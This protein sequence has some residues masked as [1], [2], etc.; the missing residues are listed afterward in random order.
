LIATI[1]AAVFVALGLYVL[2]WWGRTKST[3]VGAL[4]WPTA[5]GVITQSHIHHP[6]GPDD[7]ALLVLSFEYTIGATHYSSNSIDLFRIEERA[8][9]DEM[10]AITR[11]YRKGQSVQVYFD[12]A[13]P[14]KALLEPGNLLA[15]H[16]V[17]NLGLFLTTFGIVVFT[18]IHWFSPR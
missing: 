17:R 5:K 9:Q 16:R 1:I 12:P 13:K 10:E 2:L 7:A 3:G 11:R 18:V 15:A 8:T 4:R 14:T 6:A